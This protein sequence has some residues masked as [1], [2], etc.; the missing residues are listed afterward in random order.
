MPAAETG[1][2]AQPEGEA[3]PVPPVHAGVAY[4]G[5][6]EAEDDGDGL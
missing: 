6:P 1:K 4:V 3:D 2:E 5:G